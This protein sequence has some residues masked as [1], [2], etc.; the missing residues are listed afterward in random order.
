VTSEEDSARVAGL[1]AALAAAEAT[2]LRFRTLVEHMPAITYIQS[3]G[4]DLETFYVSPQTHSMLGFPPARWFEPDFWVSRVHPDDLVH[5]LAEDARTDATGEPFAVDYRFLRA[6]GRT[7]WVRDRAKLVTDHLGRRMWQGFIIDI[8]EQKEAEDRFRTLVEA[9]PAV[10]YTYDETATGS[11]VYLASYVSP[12][13]AEITGYDPGEFLA[14]DTALWARLLDP[15][16]A[17]RVREADLRAQRTDEPMRE[18]YRIRTRDGQVRWIYDE[19]HLFRQ[20]PGAPKGWL[21]V[22]FDI[23]DRKQAE[24]DIRRSFELLRTADADRRRLLGRIVEAQEGERRRIAA[25]IHDDP[26]QKMTAVSLRIDALGRHLEG[27]EG[28]RQLDALRETV[29][30]AI[31][32]LRHLLFE[33]HPP[34]LESDGLAA[35]LRDTLRDLGTETGVDTYL[36]DRL[37]TEPSADIRAAAYRIGQEALVNVRKHAGARHVE[38]LVEGRADGLVLRVRDDGSGFDLHTVGAAGHVGLPTM[39]ERAEMMGGHIRIETAP[40]RGTTV[41][42][43]LPEAPHALTQPA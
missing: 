3:V 5:V 43:W 28:R 31:A 9:L 17:H 30:G 35:A 32:R 21:G 24:E 11:D 1:E 34:S 16:D 39:R 20:E 2:A 18:E 13:F 29:G 38:I 40:G 15:R 6:D 10:T 14:D 12:Q 22:L 36:E 8:S 23:T 26:I 4:G 19:Q 7:R 33:L 42:A 27:A 25:D 41:E 37:V